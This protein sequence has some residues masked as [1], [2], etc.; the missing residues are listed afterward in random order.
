MPEYE[1]ICTDED[2]KHEWDAEYSIKADPPEFCPKCGK[3]TVKRLISLGGK[4]V[5]E[6]TGHDLSDKL[7][8]D[9]VKLKKELATSEKS[10]AN[11]IGEDKYQ[12]NK[13]YNEDVK[14]ETNYFKQQFRRVK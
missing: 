6:L 13:I 11:W 2:C 1:H 12:G 14:R 10:Y 8:N 9:A 4:G 7:K 3:K 5:V